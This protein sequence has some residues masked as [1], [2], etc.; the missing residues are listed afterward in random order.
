MDET[1]RF[2]VLCRWGWGWG[3]REGGGKNGFSREEPANILEM[4]MAEAASLMHQDPW[5][6]KRPSRHQ[7]CY[8]CGH[9]LQICKGDHLAVPRAVQALHTLGETRAQEL[10]SVSIAS[11][12]AQLHQNTAHLPN[13]HLLSDLGPEPKR[14]H[15]VGLLIKRSFMNMG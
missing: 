4:E 1:R 14:L 5:L 11:A 6:E 9:T 2:G 15:E 10:Q 13:V 12:V 8:D 7:L 3:V